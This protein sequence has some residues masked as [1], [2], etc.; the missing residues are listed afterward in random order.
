MPSLHGIDNLDDLPSISLTGQQAWEYARDHRVELSL[1]PLQIDQTQRLLTLQQRR[2]FGNVDLGGNLYAG[3]RRRESCWPH[4][5]PSNF[6]FRSDPS[7]NCPRRVLA[8]PGT[9]TAGCGRIGG[10]TGSTS[11]VRRVDVS[12]HPCRHLSA[13]DAGGPRE[14][15]VLCDAVLFLNAV[16]RDL[17]DRSASAD[18]RHQA[19]YLHALRKYH[20][21]AS[22]LQVALGGRIPDGQ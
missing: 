9:K 12:S 3:I 10:K 20:Q 2:I 5:G 14:R 1:A 15:R 19:R 17:S 11:V 8:P 21:T 4:T 13:Q 6:C 16:Q 7:G 22:H 18:S